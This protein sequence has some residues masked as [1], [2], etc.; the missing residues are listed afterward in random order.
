M[1][2]MKN[3]FDNPL[4]YKL[5]YVFTIDDEAHHNMLKVGETTLKSD[6]LPTNELIKTA[7]LK[8]IKSYTNTAGIA[9]KLLYTELA[10]R[11]DGTI[12]S[13]SDV[14]NV[15]KNS[16]FSN[17]TIGETTGSEWFNIDLT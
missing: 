7:A 4:K 8:R 16:G 13:D 12:F 14:H 6:S 2:N 5:I 10:I 1:I 17:Q 3:K 15:L 9:F 11:S